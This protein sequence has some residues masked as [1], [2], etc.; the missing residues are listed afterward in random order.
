MPVA[1]VVDEGVEAARPG[2]GRADRLAVESVR[3]TSSRR[4][5][6]AVALEP[7]EVGP[8]AGGRE[9]PVAPGGGLERRGAADAG[10]APC[11]KDHAFGG[12]AGMLPFSRE[13][14]RPRDR[15]AGARPSAQIRPGGSY[16]G[17]PTARLLVYS[18][19]PGTRDDCARDAAGGRRNPAD[20][21]NPR[22]QRT[23]LFEHFVRLPAE[24]HPDRVRF[25]R[26]AGEADCAAQESFLRAY[27]NLA[28][29]REGSTFE[30]WLTRIC[31]NWC[32]DRL[33][34]RKLVL[35]FHQAPAR[36][37]DD[38]EGPAELA[39]AEDPSPN[40]APRG[41][42]FATGSAGRWRPCRR[43]SGRSSP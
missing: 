24:D 21:G 40:G 2:K 41:A 26:D 36:D 34:R 14:H 12:H 28:D 8:V 16:T 9:H 42:R 22:R 4:T 18:P 31:I 29:F 20:P 38:G 6:V 27:Q 19:V 35:F 33:K 15:F 5:S 13:A 17:K 7:R 43:A 30:T 32:K 3:S 10:G 39:P 1:R 37:D 25:L 11:E 23:E